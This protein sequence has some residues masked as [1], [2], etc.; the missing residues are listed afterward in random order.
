MPFKSKYTEEDE[1]RIWEMF[2]DGK[3][4]KEVSI[5]TGLPTGTIYRIL[6]KANE[7]WGVPVQE[8]QR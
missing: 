2:A 8:P 6:Q 1:R 5:D 3:A 7:K 4:F